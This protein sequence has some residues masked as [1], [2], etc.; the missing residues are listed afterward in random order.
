MLKE[1]LCFPS[2]SHLHITVRRRRHHH[3]CPHHHCCYCL[4]Q[5]GDTWMCF[6]LFSTKTQAR[7]RTHARTGLS[8]YYSS[9]AHTTHL[10][11]NT[12][13]THT[14]LLH[15]A[16]KLNGG[17]STSPLS[18]YHPA[19]AGS[20]GFCCVH[21]WRCCTRPPNA[22]APFAVFRLGARVAQ[23]RKTLFTAHSAHPKAKRGG[24]SN[25]KKTSTM[26]AF[27]GW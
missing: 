5:S 21:F 9:Y 22:N 20:N 15:Q 7:A 11:L 19:T 3:T 10:P 26:V 23:G 16:Q 14:C 17:S 1:S 4:M 18:P 8:P 12:A 27:W 13:P 24:A 2:L 25:I 6:I